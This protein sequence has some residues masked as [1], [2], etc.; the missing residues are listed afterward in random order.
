MK[1]RVIIAA[2]AA[3]GLFSPLLAIGQ[4]VAPAGSQPP[5]VLQVYR[6]EIKPG[7]APAH[8]LFEASW[9]RAFAKAK[10]PTHYLAAT[11]LTG[12][13]EAWFMTGYDSFAEWEKDNSSLD[14]SPELKSELE[15]LEAGD[16]EFRSGG[17]SLVVSYREDL[18][19][20]ANVDLSK[21]RYFR[22][23]TYNLRQGHTLDFS[24]AVKIVR[25]GYRKLG[26]ELHW[27]TY[28]VVSGLPSP[29]Y[30]LFIPMKSL[31]EIDAGLGRDKALREAEGDD[32]EKLQKIAADGY[33]STESNIF[34]FN[35]KMSYPPKE[36]IAG[37]PEFWTAKA[38]VKTASR[39]KAGGKKLAAH[40]P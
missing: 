13:S 11:S 23:V 24:E 15:R 12:P 35:P 2:T 26:V 28:Q 21:M 33:V 34:A 36:W 30:V 16:G 3:F 40:K 29:S 37:D 14:K 32:A 22:I 39:Q 19:D 1:N 18:S 38:A 8:A 20:F 9:P 27:A 25:A 17:S 7:K 31:D 4:S 5:K 10:W 6:E